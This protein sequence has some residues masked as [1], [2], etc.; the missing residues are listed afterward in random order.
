MRWRRDSRAPRKAVPE[1]AGRLRRSSTL[2]ASSHP[3][4]GRSAPSAGPSPHSSSGTLPAPD[5]QSQAMRFRPASSRDSDGTLRSASPQWTASQNPRQIPPRLPPRVRRSTPHRPTQARSR[6][7][8]PRR[9]PSKTRTSSTGSCPAILL[10][11]PQAPV[12]NT[13]NTS[14]RT[15]VAEPASDVQSAAQPWPIA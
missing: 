11:P 15:R 4:R 14:V 9:G 7:I 1:P 8:R 2:C 5:G 10:S 13:G 12:G 3:T 6:S